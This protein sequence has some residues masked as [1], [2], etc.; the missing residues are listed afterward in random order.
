M[1]TRLSCTGA[2]FFLFFLKT[3]KMYHPPHDKQHGLWNNQTE[4]KKEGGTFMDLIPEKPQITGNYFCTWDAQC[5]QMYTWKERP[6]DRTA[7]DSM[8]EAFLFGENGLL[9]SFDGVRED[10]IVVLDDG[11]GVPG[12]S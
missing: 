8:C 5:D 3:G 7:R 6:A 2:I 11:W 12:N 4:I 1:I 9:R 10:L